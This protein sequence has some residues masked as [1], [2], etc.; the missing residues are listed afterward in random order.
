LMMMRVYVCVYT[1]LEILQKAMHASKQISPNI[2][3]RIKP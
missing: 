3:D 1:G 2:Q